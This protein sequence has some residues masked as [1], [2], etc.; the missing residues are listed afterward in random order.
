[1]SDEELQAIVNSGNDQSGVG[2]VGNALNKIADVQQS[3]VQAVADAGAVV[4][5]SLQQGATNFAGKGALLLRNV[6]DVIGLTD[7]ART[8]EIQNNLYK[9]QQEQAQFN[10]SKGHPTLGKVAEVAGEIAPSLLAGGAVVKGVKAAIGGVAGAAAG[11]GRLADVAANTASGF[12]TS[13][14]GSG[15]KAPAE[16]LRSGLVGASVGGALGAATNLAGKGLEKLQGGKFV[17][18]NAKAEAFRAAG[19]QPRPSQIA[20]STVN[21]KVQKFY[22]GVE[23]TLNKI[24]F[25]GIKNKVRN[26]QMKFEETT[27]KVINEMDAGLPDPSPLFNAAKDG[28]DKTKAY[29]LGGIQRTIDG[30]VKNMSNNPAYAKNPKVIEYLDQ[31]KGVKNL[32]FEELHQSR[33]GVD[34]FIKVLKKNL[35]DPATKEDFNALAKIRGQMSDSLAAIAR[36][37]GKAKQ[38]QSANQASQDRMVIDEI[39]EAYTG[40]TKAGGLVFEPARFN[41]NL[42]KALAHLKDEVKISLPPQYETAIKNM[43]KL[44]DVMV[45]TKIKPGLPGLS[46]NLQ[47]IGGMALGGAA[48]AYAFSDASTEVTV[49]ATI[50]AGLAGML[51]TKAG[52]NALS[53][54]GSVSAKNPKVRSLIGSALAIGQAKELHDQENQARA[55]EQP[56]DFDSLSDAELEAIANQGQ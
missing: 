30:A 17:V 10:E 48:G 20:S 5:S 22:E 32:T 52:V 11:A 3:G 55:S 27:N 39:K 16:M 31:L 34:Q 43:K 50:V 28:I 46:G 47:G 6:S 4:G 18:D 36:T 25:V 53:S 29:A 44:S 8:K 13:L 49:G 2:V 24:P 35:K 14:L 41:Q 37:N 7:P 33:Q 38:W 26:A 12:S 21:P 54:I 45:A 51:T 19:I 23:N 56:I 40:A 9:M 15:D 1:M 42:D